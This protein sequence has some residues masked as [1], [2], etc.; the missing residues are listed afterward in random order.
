M[1]LA[2]LFP[3]LMLGGCNPADVSD[4][5]RRDLPAPAKVCTEDIPVPYP[6]VGESWRIVG[7]RALEAAENMHGHRQACAEWYARLRA[8]YAKG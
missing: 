1:M 7:L 2:A 6:K 8:R 3:T 5:V 4:T